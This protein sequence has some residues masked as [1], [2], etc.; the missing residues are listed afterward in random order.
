MIIICDSITKR[1]GCLEIVKRTMSSNTKNDDD[2]KQK[3]S[4]YDFS[5][6]DIDGN[7]VSFEKYKN[8]PLIVVNVATNC[9]LTKSNYKQLNQLYD[10]FENEGLR[11]AAFPCNQF[12][13]QEPGCDVEIKEFIKKNG[14]RFDMFAKIDVNGNNAHP[15]YKWLKTKQGGFLGFDGIKWNFTKFLVDKDGQPIKRYAPNFEPKD[16]EPDI[17]KIL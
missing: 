7:E 3:N 8:H 13:G 11:I 6:V 12:A 16:I 17:D 5:A 1:Y 2:W 10:R 15:L 14:V 9:G 4:I